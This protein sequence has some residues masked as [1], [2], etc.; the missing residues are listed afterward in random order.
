MAPSFLRMIR[1]AIPTSSHYI[2]HSFF[3][4]ANYLRT[5]PT[6]EA[7]RIAYQISGDLASAASDASAP[8]L[9]RK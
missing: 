6:L 9:F 8:Q 4:P 7:Q 5:V 2:E 3:D 1:R